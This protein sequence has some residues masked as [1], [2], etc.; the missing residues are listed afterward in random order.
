V[1]IGIVIGGSIRRKGTDCPQCAEI[2]RAHEV[3][4]ERQQA[5]S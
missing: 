3:R 4:D 1:A 5:R 2:H